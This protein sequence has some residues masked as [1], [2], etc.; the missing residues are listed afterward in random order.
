MLDFAAD[1][2]DC[3]VQFCLVLPSHY[4]ASLFLQHAPNLSVESNKDGSPN[5]TAESKRGKYRVQKYT[6]RETMST[7]FTFI[8]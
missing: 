5:K 7:V 3:G 1:Y 4:A 6:L 8:N 2:F